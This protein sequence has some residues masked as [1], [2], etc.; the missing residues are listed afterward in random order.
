[1]FTLPPIV[2]SESRQLAVPT[3]PPQE[4]V[5]G[6]KEI[7]AVLW[8]QQVVATGQADLIAKAM[9][10]LK[11]IKTPMATLEKRYRDFVMA[12]NPGSLFAALSTFGFGDLR[13]QA[14]RAVNRKASAQEAIAR[15]GSEE[16]C[17]TD[18]PAEG[19]IIA[20]LKD[21]VFCGD[22]GFPQLTPDVKTGFQQASDFLPHTLS[23]CLHELRYWSDLYRLRHAIDSDCGDSLYEEWVRRD[24]I[25][26]LMTT[27]RPRDKEEALSVMRFMLSDEDGSDHRDRTEADAIFLNLLR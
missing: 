24:F 22:S 1:M 27:I 20:T 19:F 15:F 5:T 16:A 26:H 25:F 9:E 10:A 21:I 11:K 6:D 17:F 18:T 23:D 8:L 14:E 7:D 2:E 4:E 3:I 12:K 13:G